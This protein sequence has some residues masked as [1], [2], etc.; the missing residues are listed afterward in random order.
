MIVLFLNFVDQIQ[1]ILGSKQQKKK[2]HSKFNLLLQV[3]NLDFVRRIQD[4][5]K[6]NSNEFEIFGS[7]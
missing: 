4:W 7:K 3:I 1:E 2:Y 5:I 6:I